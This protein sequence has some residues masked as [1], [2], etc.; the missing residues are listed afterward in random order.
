MPIRVL[1]LAITMS[2]TALASAATAGQAR[3]RA[4]GPYRAGLE[5]LR[6]ERWAEAA[7]AF[8]RATEIDPTFEMAYYALGRANMPQKKYAEAARALTRCRDLYLADAGKAFS[9]SHEAQQ[10][11]RD[12]ITHVD[13]LIR[14][15]Q[16]GPQSMQTAE[17]LRQLR[18]T[19]RQLQDS[20]QRGSAISI[21]T[22]VPPYVSMALGSALFRLGRMADAEREYKATIAT[23]P[24]T[25]EAHN[26]L[27]VVYLQT[28]R[29]EEAEKSVKAAE[30]AGFRVHAMLKE[31]IA[32]GKKGGK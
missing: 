13:D 8:Q 27:A 11:R 16:S 12:R 3:D 26:N 7:A 17:T 2:L 23:D 31:D 24:K 1:L 4:M 19:R 30:K 9:N 20:V 5:D 25:G 6:A 22:S 15:F 29:Y 14:Q 21:E 18:E 28:G 32:A 10:R